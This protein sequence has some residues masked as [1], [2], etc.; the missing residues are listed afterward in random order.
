MVENN[1]TK[2]MD[3]SEDTTDR[4]DEEFNMFPSF[5]TGDL[6]LPPSL[7]SSIFVDHSSGRSA[8]AGCSDIYYVFAFLAFLCELAETV[9]VSRV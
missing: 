7:Y 2:P 8:S 6:G 4:N 9:R 3:T 5:L 1:S